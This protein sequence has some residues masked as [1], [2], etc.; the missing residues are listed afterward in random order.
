MSPLLDPLRAQG[1]ISA[2]DENLA[3]TLGRLAGEATPEVLLA[4]ALTSRQLR[5]GHTCLDLTSLAGKPVQEALEGAEA[6]ADAGEQAE[7]H[8][9]PPFAAW[10]RALEAS[11][12]VE[13]GVS[14]A[15][16]RPL[17]LDSEGRIFLRRYREHQERLAAAIRI[18]A[19]VALPDL[20]TDLLG[21]GLQRLF[22]RPPGLAEEEADWQKIAALVACR[23]RFAL[24]SGGPGTGKTTTVVKILALWVEQALAAGR[25]LP[26]I[27]LLAP[28]GKAAARL[29]ESVEGAR[30]RLDLPPRV[31]AAIPEQASTVHRRL[32]PRGSRGGRFRHGP[33]NPLATDL[34][35]LD[36]ASMV[37]L[38]LMDRLVAALPQEAALL[39]LGDRDQLVSVAAGSVLADLTV[40]AQ[41]GY[42]RQLRQE[43]AVVAAEKLTKESAVAEEAG[44]P[45]EG[46]DGGGS[47][48]EAVGPGALRDCVVRLRHSYRYGSDSGIG[49]LAEAIRRGLVA[50]ALALL[51]AEE[52]ADV[53][54]LPALTG[55]ALPAGL[56]G[57]A[58]AAFREV[59]EVDADDI[60]GRLLAQERFRV[61]TA[62]RL[63]PYGA[64][65]LASRIEA[66]LRS[67]GLVPSGDEAYPGQPL[68]ITRNDY[69]LGLFNGDLGIVGLAGK[70]LRAF[71]PAVDGPREVALGRLPPH[72]TAF[73][74]SIHK[75]QGSE[76]DSVAIVLPEAGARVLGRELLY[77]AVTRARREVKIHATEE[78]IAAA[79]ERPVLRDSGMA[80]LLA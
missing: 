31:A 35:L 22:P 12:L 55:E 43:I 78:A 14:G 33:E 71:F 44:E 25:P 69:G 9:L 11:P 61:L 40:A 27:D 18:R 77:T 4:V 6:P 57:R 3:R 46:G 79:I 5:D 70:R 67:A 2:L 80:S 1:L 50:E 41:D 60:P 64:E 19:D 39:L 56:E 68:L 49:R 54:L 17:I 59:L 38:V 15:S 42:S 51:A 24:I 45:E 48:G 47:K 65:T 20:N 58:N 32:R 62:N 53:R 28:T 7:A 23:R 13:K 16:S 10:L 8:L 36:E 26:R 73:A 72:E 34:V 76:L 74:M 21:E 52:L 63:G 37:D 66:S 30:R 29:L 75:S